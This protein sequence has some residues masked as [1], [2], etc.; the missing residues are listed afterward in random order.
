VPRATSAEEQ[1]HILDRELCR[2]P[3]FGQVANVR[4]GSLADIR[5]R[6]RDVRFTPNSGHSS[7]P[8]T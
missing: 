4:F 2:E 5:V 6:P 1:Y 3:P 8:A 7:S